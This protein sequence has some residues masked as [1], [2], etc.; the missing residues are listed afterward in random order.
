M[1]VNGN[2]VSFGKKTVNAVGAMARV[3]KAII[4]QKPVIVPPEVL[5]EREAIC[6]ACEFNIN[7]TC[8]K[9]GCG[10]RRQFIRKPQLATE[11]CPLP[12]PKWLEYTR[13]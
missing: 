7:G 1:K 13:N 2:R 9:C 4:E 11:R 6:A 3:S 12:E 5:K 8:S 10:V